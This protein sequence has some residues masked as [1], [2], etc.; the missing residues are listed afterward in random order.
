MSARRRHQHRPPILTTTTTARPPI[1]PTPLVPRLLSLSP[2]P[3]LDDHFTGKTLE[4]PELKAGLSGLVTKRKFTGEEEAARKDAAD[5]K[6][7]KVQQL[8]RVK[9]TRTV[10]S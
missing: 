2:S 4:E 3:Q 7:K 1:I 6:A 5:K 10:Q 9:C 8:Y